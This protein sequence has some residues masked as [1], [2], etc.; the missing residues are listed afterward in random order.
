MFVHM[1]VYITYISA[2]LRCVCVQCKNIFA[3]WK[4]VVNTTILYIL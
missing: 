1:C 3:V 4:S 2:D